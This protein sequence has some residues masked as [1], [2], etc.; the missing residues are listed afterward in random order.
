MKASLIKLPIFATLM[1]M[2]ISLAPAAD[3]AAPPVKQPDEATMKVV[4]A[5]QELHKEKKYQESEALLT[6]AIADGN[7]HITV[8]MALAVSYAYQKEFKKASEL[9]GKAWAETKDVGM[10]ESYSVALLQQKDIEGLKKISEDLL[11]HFDKMKE[12][13]LAVIMVATA[14]G[15][16]SL[17]NR[18]IAKIPTEEITKDKQLAMI[19]AKAAKKIAEDSLKEKK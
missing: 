3:E 15:D 9:Y 2:L 19:L 5:A 8:K 14:E 16:Q 12:G 17:F 1:A 6:K 4:Q 18:A 13:R 7:D 10:L 11:T